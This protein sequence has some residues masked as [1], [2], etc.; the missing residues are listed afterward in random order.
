VAEVALAVTLAS[1]AALLGRS[2]MRVYAVDPGFESANVLMMQLAVP[3]E[4]A[5]AERVAFC[6]N[7]V[8]SVE[9]LPGVVAAGAVNDF[10]VPERPDQ[11][12][13][14]EGGPDAAHEFVAELRSA[15]DGA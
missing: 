6:R 3:R 14:V 13:F 12:V 4:R 9:G 10:F 1:G 2:L 5:D 8:A 15:L 11:A 7:A